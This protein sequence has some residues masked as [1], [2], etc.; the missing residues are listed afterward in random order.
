MQ[1]KIEELD[2]VLILLSLPCLIS[3]GRL[4]VRR[5]LNCGNLYI[6]ILVEKPYQTYNIV[7]NRVATIEIG[8]EDWLIRCER[9]EVPTVTAATKLVDIVVEKVLGMS[10][11]YRI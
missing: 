7:K 8:V 4:T 1:K 3:G 9:H 5:R 10:C 2:D 11:G 6:D